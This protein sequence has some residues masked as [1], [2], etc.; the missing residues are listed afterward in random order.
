MPESCLA[1]P[2]TAL[3]EEQCPFDPV[4]MC[5]EI[6]A[7]QTPEFF[8]LWESW[9]KEAGKEAWPP[10]WA[11][12][13]PAASLLGRWIIDHPELVRGK[14]VLD[15]GC[16]G[17]VA[18]IAAAMAGAASVVCNDID[19]ASLA[20]A[21]ENARANGVS[22]A[23]DRSDRLGTRF[24]GGENVV[25]VADM[26]Y[27]KPEAL[28]LSELLDKAVARGALVLVSDGGR[29]FAPK[30]GFERLAEADL[31]VLATLEGVENRRVSLFRYA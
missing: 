15:I 22:V 24:D 28:A 25:L 7:R 10:F 17:G 14:S 19:A 29:P 6:R 11:V 13:W 2:S 4:M 21:E 12:V 18:G 5:P 27:K 16:G 9:E 31:P 26:F 3:L 23:T 1:K 20:L 8:T 30:G